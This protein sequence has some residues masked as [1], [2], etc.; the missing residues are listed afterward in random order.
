MMSCCCTLSIYGCTL[1]IYGYKEEQQKANAGCMSLLCLP[2][3][4]S[5]S[6]SN[7]SNQYMSVR[8]D[9][10]ECGKSLSLVLSKA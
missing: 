6:V 7:A 1:S 9:F 4:N 5:G 10:C 2:F 3:H 8:A